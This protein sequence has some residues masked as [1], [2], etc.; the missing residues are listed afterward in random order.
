VTLVLG[1]YTIRKPL[2]L[3]ATGLVGAAGAPLAMVVTKL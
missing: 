3:T 2:S 1:K